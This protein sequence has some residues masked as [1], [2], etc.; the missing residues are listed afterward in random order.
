MVFV[1]CAPICIP[2]PNEPQRNSNFK[3]KFLDAANLQFPLFHPS[4]THF[5]L[6]DRFLPPPPTLL[7]FIPFP[8][9]KKSNPREF[10]PRVHA[11]TFGRLFL[12]SSVTRCQLLRETRN[13]LEKKV[14][15]KGK[16]IGRSECTEYCLNVGDLY[17]K[18]RCAMPLRKGFLRPLGGVICPNHII[19][20]RTH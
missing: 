20:Q 5:A 7:P 19:L 15:W 14:L 16:K 2:C 3:Q 13:C 18:V 1:A 10:C 4:L 11:Y 8:I 17:E 6:S 9:G 12:L